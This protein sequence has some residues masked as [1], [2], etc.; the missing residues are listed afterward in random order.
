MRVLFYGGCH[1]AALA[2]VFKRNCKSLEHVDHLTNFQLI[3]SGEP[4]PYEYIGSF[5]RVVFS[6]IRNKRE[7][8]TIHLEN[9]L[10]ARGIHFFKYP[11]LQWEGYFPGTARSPYSWY[12]GWWPASLE[13]LAEECTS[14]DAF[15]DEIYAGNALRELVAP[16]FERTTQRLEQ[17]EKD[18]DIAISSIILSSYRDKRLLLTNDHA[19]IELYKPIAE[20]VARWLNCRLDP[21]FHHSTTEVQLGIQCPVLPSV[22]DEL[23]IRFPGGDFTNKMMIGADVLSISEYAS[24]AWDAKSIHLAIAAT[25]TRV[26]FSAPQ[27][28]LRPIPIKRGEMFL[29]RDRRSERI[30]PYHQYELIAV[31][32]GSGRIDRQSC[33]G[34]FLLYRP[35]WN[36]LR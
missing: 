8:K 12:T 19:G 22:I 4:V 33:P 28:Q 23:G 32:K 3:R 24:L 17:G 15:L 36:G 29:V 16:N 35:H 6:P 11:W 10:R 20:E 34:D 31:R 9:F 2:R 5:E 25:D 30:G 1:A 21:A 27:P 18:C 13:R 7:Y 26:Y 14:K